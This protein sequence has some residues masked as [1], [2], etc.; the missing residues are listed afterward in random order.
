LL[1]MILKSHQTT[2]L[3]APE[4]GRS[5]EEFK[6]AEELLL[7]LVKSHLSMPETAP[8]LGKNAEELTHLTPD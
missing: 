7:L 3:I 5:A 2:L 1:K 4:P 6:M 8:E